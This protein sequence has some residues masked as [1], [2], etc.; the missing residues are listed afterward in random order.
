MLTQTEA[1]NSSATLA[2]QSRTL[3]EATSHRGRMDIL[4]RFLPQPTMGGEVRDHGDC[5]KRCGA[6]KS[7][8]VS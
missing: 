8:K 3:S 4:P 6:L 2:V 5:A 7:D 1:V